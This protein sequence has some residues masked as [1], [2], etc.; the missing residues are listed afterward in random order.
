MFQV[1]CMRQIYEGA[2]RTFIWLGVADETSI[3]IFSIS[4]VVLGRDQTASD[5]RR[6]RVDMSIPQEYEMETPWIRQNLVLQSFFENPW[7]T[8]VWIIQE[9]AVSQRPV[10]IS[11]PLELGWDDFIYGVTIAA[12]LTM[13]QYDYAGIARLQQLRAICRAVSDDE[14][15]PLLSLLPGTR[16]FKATDSRDKIY[17][18]LGLATGMES[19][20][21][22]PD[23]SLT[24]ENVFKKVAKILLLSYNTLDLLNVPRPT[25]TEEAFSLPSWV[26]NWKPEIVLGMS[27]HSYPSQPSLKQR[28][29]RAV[30]AR[31]SMPPL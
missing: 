28:K 24:V 9:V 5:Q 21:I 27:F 29:A 31:T 3:Q 10:L 20:E 8:R 18:L 4:L 30:S 17:G 13:T 11:A 6:S 23:Y 16:N 12:E 15:L 26:P 7:F 2:T 1:L 25:I 22:Q 14:P 19:R